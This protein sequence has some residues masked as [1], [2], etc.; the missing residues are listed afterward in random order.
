MDQK[1]NVRPKKLR[2]SEDIHEKLYNTEFVNDL[3]NMTPRA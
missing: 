1:L 2:H 3:L